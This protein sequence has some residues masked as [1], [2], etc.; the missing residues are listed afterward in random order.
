MFRFD[1]ILRTARRSPLLLVLLA[2]LLVVPGCGSE[3]GGGGGN[4]TADAG[5]QDGAGAVDGTAADGV[6]DDGGSADGVAGDAGGTDTTAGDAADGPAVYPIGVTTIEIVGASG[7]KLPVE[8]WYPAKPAPGSQ[9]AKYAGGLASSPFGAVRDTAPESPPSAK[10]WPLVVF[11]HGNGGIR[12]QSVFLTEWLARNGFVV[13]SPEH[14]GNSIFTMDESLTAV[15]PLWRPLDVRATVDH[16]AAGPSGKDPAFLKDLADT[17]AYAMMGHSFGGF[18]TLAISGFK[19]RVPP[20]FKL[21]CSSVEAP[22]ALCDEIADMGPQPWDLH[23]PRCKVG[24]PLAPAGYGWQMLEKLKGDE[25]LPP[26]FIM[27]ATGDKLTP[28]ATE[29]TPVFEDLP[30][31]GALLLITGSNHYVFSDICALEKVLPASFKAQLGDMCSPN[32]QPSLAEVHAEVAD[33]ALAAARYWLLDDKSAE[34][35]LTAPAKAWFTLQ[36]KGIGN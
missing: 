16:L 10:G 24:V 12:E 33:R 35:A 31:V 26:L 5:G 23:D 22:K 13:A 14:V 4:A 30:G 20:Q 19:V 8:I 21:D 17:D 18:T 28:S 29:Q 1:P 11:S 15:M 2:A 25:K 3:D 6:S 7:R 32:T 9:A 36:T 34:P 27:G